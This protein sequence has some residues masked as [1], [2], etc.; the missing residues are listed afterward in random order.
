M[1]E[2]SRYRG[3]KREKENAGRGER[4][5][6]DARSSLRIIN[7]ELRGLRD[8][9]L[10]PRVSRVPRS[11]V[12]AVPEVHDSRV[13]RELSHV[14]RSAPSRVP[15]VPSPSCTP[16]PTCR[17]HDDARSSAVSRRPRCPAHVRSLA[18]SFVRSLALSL[19][20]SLAASCTT[21]LYVPWKHALAASGPNKLSLLYFSPDARPF[22]LP[23]LHEYVREGLLSLPL[24]FPFLLLLRFFLLTLTLAPLLLAAAAYLYT[25]GRRRRAD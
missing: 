8:L 23:R 24:S 18:R 4:E 12:S 20:R 13:T 25:S 1:P 7:A 5:V 6:A 16:P 14:T 3:S 10:E 15:R 9:S 22:Q 19:A 2:T 11:S 17:Q 21:G